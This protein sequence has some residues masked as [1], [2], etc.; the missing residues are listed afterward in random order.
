MQVW[1]L[2]SGSSGNCY[3]V[4]EQDT[5]IL[6]EAGLGIRRIEHELSRLGILPA[7]LKAIVVSHEHTDHWA[8]ALRLGR[9]L[10][11]PVV[12]TPGTW[13][14]G[15]GQNADSCE[16]LEIVAGRTVQVGGVAVEAF[17]LPHDAREPAGFILRSGASSVLLATDMGFAGP[18]VIGLAREADLVI[19]ESN[20]DVN[21][22]LRGPYP[23]RL[24]TRILGDH[25]HLSNEGAARAIVDISN[26]RQHQFWLAHLS[27]ANNT[28]RLALVSVQE[29]L[30]REGLGDLSVSVALRD[31]RSLFWDSD[32]AVA[33]L[34]LF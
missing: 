32:S 12:C 33:Q 1:S 2:S 23:A 15:G 5:L 29:I 21:M 19:L 30:R 10:K 6:L 27:H 13:E 3:L 9:R 11:V 18:E 20:H 24:K 25:G 26:G 31:Q 28:P 8:S 17:S 4:R 22:L 16:Y 7:Q 34:R 14:A